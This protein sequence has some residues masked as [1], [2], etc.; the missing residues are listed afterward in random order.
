MDT[1]STLTPV[2]RDKDLI[3]FD[4]VCNLCNGSV[5]FVLDRDHARR[6]VFGSLQSERS[7]EILHSYNYDTEALNSI[8]VITKSGKL[9]TRSDAALY[10]ARQLPGGWKL[11]YIFKIIPRFIRD[12]V[13]DL[14]AANRYKWFGRQ[15][16]CRMPNPE[17]KQRFL[18]AY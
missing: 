1:H 4:G 17:L 15:D 12:A 14:I 11:L 5:S 10:I 2:G 16:A 13:Y 6:F 8:V 3:L 7:K 18:D 9:M